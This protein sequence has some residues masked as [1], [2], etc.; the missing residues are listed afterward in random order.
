MNSINFSDKCRDLGIGKIENKLSNLAKRKCD[1]N[2]SQIH[3]KNKID[4]V[5]LMSLNLNFYKFSEMIREREREI[6]IDSLPVCLC[7]GI[8]SFLL[9]RTRERSFFLLEDTDRLVLGRKLK[10]NLVILS[11]ICFCKI[12]VWPSDC[13]TRGISFE[14]HWYYTLCMSLST[15]I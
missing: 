1:S 2:S 11:L 5:I 6:G 15:K 12:M 7:G 4:K 14:L 13:T 9:F 10:D 8:F 3:Q